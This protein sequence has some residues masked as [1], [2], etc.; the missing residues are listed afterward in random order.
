MQM[1]QRSLIDMLSENINKNTKIV[2]QIK[3][4]IK[5]KKHRY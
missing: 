5:R 2:R 1:I 4:S 3:T